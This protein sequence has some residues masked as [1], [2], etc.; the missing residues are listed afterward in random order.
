MSLQV[1]GPAGKGAKAV[2]W[3]ETRLP[4]QTW[5]VDCQGRI[6]SQMFEDMVLD[7]KG[8]PSAPGVPRDAPKMGCSHQERGLPSPNLPLAL[9]AAAATT[10]TTPS[11][12]TWP[13]NDPRSSGTSRCSEGHPWAGWGH[14]ASVPTLGQEAS[15]PSTLH[16]KLLV[17]R[18]ITILSITGGPPHLPPRRPEH[19]P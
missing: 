15:D 3:S 18:M 9:Q 8:E 10:G 14:P 2:L 6:H 13:R 4:R 19:G 17:W 5:S 7:I 12:G 16:P 11:C 1:I